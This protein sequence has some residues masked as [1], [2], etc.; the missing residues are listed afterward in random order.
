MDSWAPNSCQMHF[1][2]DNPMVIR[3]GFFE[4][5]ADF[6]YNVRGIETIVGLVPADNEKAIKLDKRI[7]FKEALRIPNGYKD[8]IDY[9]VM[10]MTREDC[11]WLKQEAA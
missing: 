5:V 7:G 9:V 2:I 8:G 11:R 1:A 10:L 3:H 6:C 4:T